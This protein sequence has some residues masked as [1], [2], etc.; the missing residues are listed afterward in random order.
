MFDS[1]RAHREQNRSVEIHWSVF[2]L[3][4]SVGIESSDKPQLADITPHRDM[5]LPHVVEALGSIAES[6]KAI[7]SIIQAADSCFSFTI[8]KRPMSRSN[9]LYY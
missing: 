6:K 4:A 2:P 8:S 1:L 9:L 7:L 3:C 5:Y